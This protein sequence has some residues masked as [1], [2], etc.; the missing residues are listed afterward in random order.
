MEYWI[1][2]TQIPYVGCITAKRL[3]DTFK[4][5]KRIYEIE[6]EKIKNVKGITIRQIES[7][8]QHRSLEQAK[9]IL[10]NCRKNKISILTQENAFYPYKAKI[11]DDAPILLYFQGNLKS[12]HQTIGIV[13]ARRCNQDIKRYCYEL[14]EK[15]VHDGKAIVSGM[16]KGIDACAATACINTGGYTIAILGNGLDICYPAEHQILMDKIRETGLLLS[17]YPPGVMPTKYTFP[18]R[19]RLISA[20]SDQVVV[21]AAGKGSGAWITAEYAKKYKRRV[22]IKSRS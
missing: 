8:Q 11:L 15:Y 7:I 18:Q 17:E 3:L 22:E 21:M 2:L 16:A 13:G 1:W 14:T 10:E 20:W 19:N 9:N 6:A 5:P 4:S 12:L